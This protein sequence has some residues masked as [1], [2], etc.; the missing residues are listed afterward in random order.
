MI[1]KNFAFLVSHIMKVCIRVSFLCGKLVNLQI[2]MKFP[3]VL[4]LNSLGERQTWERIIPVDFYRRVT[5]S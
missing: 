4:L 3:P 1:Y 2:V 5:A